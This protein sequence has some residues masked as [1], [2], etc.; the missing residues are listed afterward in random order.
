MTAIDSTISALSTRRDDVVSRLSDLRKR[1]RLH[2]VVAG[3]TRIVAEAIGLALLSLLVDRWL[4]LGRPMRMWLLFLALSWLA[5][6]IWRFIILPLR[7]KIGLVDLA[8]EVDRTDPF[9]RS[10][11]APRVATVLELPS[12]LSGPLAPS[13]AMVTRAV[14][15]AHESL[16]NVNFLAR[17][18]HKRFNFQLSSIACMLIACII[19]SVAAPATAGLWARR[20]FAG[21]NEPW[22]QKTYLTIAGLDNGRIIVPR[23]EPFVIR[24]SVR[25]GSEAP[26]AVALKIR[27]EHGAKINGVMTKFGNADWRYDV[28]SVQQ[29][30]SVEVFGGDDDLGPF[31]IEPVDR[32]RIT[33]LELISQHPTEANPTN[34]LF[35]GQEADLAF[36]AKTKLE[37]R[38]D[39]N[40][41]IEQAVI[42]NAA[43]PA[44]AVNRT[45]D[46]TFTCS[47]NHEKSMQLEIELTGTQAHLTSVPVPLSVGLKVDQAP[48][49]TLSYTGVRQRITPMAHIPLTLAAR[50][51]YGVVHLDLASKTEFLDPEKKIQTTATTQTIY[52]PVKPAK[53]MDVQIKQTFEVAPM[54]L[55]VGALLSVNGIAED[56]NYLGAQKAQS[57]PASFRIVQPDELF[58]EILVRQQ[59]ERAK[60]R[61]AIDAAQKIRDQL[62]TVTEP[63]VQQL[64]RD[65]RTIQREAMR[66][67]TSLT[68]SIIEMKLNEL[69]G[70]E[71][72]DLMEKKVLKPLATLNE[73][74]MN[75]QRDA[76]EA[77]GKAD[78]PAKVA[79]VAGRQEQIVSSMNDILKQMAQWDSFVDVINQLNEIIRMQEKAKSQTDELRTKQVKDIFE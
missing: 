65:H 7:A 44:P 20:W 74:L 40:V 50:D 39:S 37:L 75:P 58:K 11:I 29:P 27:E 53:E 36:L 26:D 8:Y 47:W 13:P 59:G 69:G 1:V 60:F 46:K 33:K 70:A 42:R 48:R 54:K 79:D 15:H 17:L 66:I 45:S 41:P 35:T 19:L 2:L 49:V 71:T 57:R 43:G 14:E 24:A 67:S 73:Q 64:S 31:F 12:L 63:M 72:Y 4:R 21:S 16:K 3:A 78:D 32:P 68:E 9:N 76:F 18:D 56:E 34:H 55:A 61:K 6:E 62:N 51:D 23:G 10:N 77:L 28:A 38:F 25:Q 30:M 22:P 52:G 5:Y